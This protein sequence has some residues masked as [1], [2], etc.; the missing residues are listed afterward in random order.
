VTAARLLADADAFAERKHRG[1]FRRDGRT[2][3]VEHPRAVCRILRD[4]FGVSDPEVLA[5]G[6]LHDTLEDTATDF[7][8]LEERFGRR[9]AAL[10]AV[11]TKDKRL[12]ESRRERVYFDALAGA[13][14]AAKLCKLADTIHN[15]RDSDDAHRP[16]AQGKG[17]RLLRVIGRPAA[18]KR[19]L[20]LLDRELAR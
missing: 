3:Y 17:R 20:G 5:A 15:C 11:L 2:P 18:L 6:L 10:V 7:D 14:L 8:D 1:Q 9:V 19:A 16:K 12:P 13:P 4:E